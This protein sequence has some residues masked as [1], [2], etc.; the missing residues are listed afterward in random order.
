MNDSKLKTKLIT[1]LIFSIFGIIY[2]QIVTIFIAKTNHLI[3]YYPFYYSIIWAYKSYSVNTNVFNAILE[4]F[5]A[6]F[7]VLVAGMV[8]AARY[9]YAVINH[10][11]LNKNLHGSARWAKYKDIEKA[12]LFSSNGVIVGAVEYKNKPKYLIHDG[13]EHILTYAPTR[14]GKGVGLIV[15]TLTTWKH[16]VIATDI[17]GELWSMTA[18]YRKQYLNN[19][20]M[21]F[22]PASID[23]VKWNPFDEI[24]VGTVDEVADAQSLA[25]LIVDPQ[26]KGLEDHWVK[27]AYSLI[28]GCIL[29]LLEKKSKRELEANMKALDRLISDTSRPLTELWEDMKNSKNEIARQVGQ[30]MLDNSWELVLEGDGRKWIGPGHNSV[31]IQDDEGTD[32]MIY[33]SYYYKEKGNKSTFA[34]RHGMLDRLQWTDDGWP[35]IKNH[36][37]SESD[38]I[39]VFYK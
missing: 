1:L 16:S 14:S 33:H 12:G 6:C 21:K 22:E 9:N 37:P 27:S 18:G 19:L 7:I 3:G 30:D 31:I 36:L 23:S 24:R 35:Y 4:K 26:G 15:P 29:Y 11:K 10:Q 13:A 8:S 25:L 5:A 38:L 28:T 20:V 2:L 17:K 39:P 32:W 34:G